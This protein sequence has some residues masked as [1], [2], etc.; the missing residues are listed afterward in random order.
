LEAERSVGR[1]RVNTTIAKNILEDM[2]YK[3]CWILLDVMDCEVLI[4][5]IMTRVLTPS[6]WT[7]IATSLLY[8]VHPGPLPVSLAQFVPSNE[9]GFLTYKTDMK[10]SGGT[11][12]IAPVFFV[13]LL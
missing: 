7:T 10:S 4:Q 9:K 11:I 12:L 5:G 2:G 8:L 6:C 1:N 3:D 13:V